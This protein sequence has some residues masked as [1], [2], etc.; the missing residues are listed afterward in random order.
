MKKMLPILIL[1]AIVFAAC[2]TNSATSDASKIQSG[3]VQFVDTAGLAQFQ[4]WKAQNELSSVNSYKGT[5]PQSAM[6]VQKTVVYYV[7]KHSSSSRSASRSYNSGNYNSVSGNTALRKKGWSKAAKGAAIGAGGGAILGAI[8]NK[9][10]PL[11]GGV[12]GGILGGA[13]GYGYG[14]SLDKKDGRY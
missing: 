4:Q 3:Q 14:H 5:I 2:H 11:V 12:I 8:I 6:P 7:P 1:I 13:A 10:N 9:R